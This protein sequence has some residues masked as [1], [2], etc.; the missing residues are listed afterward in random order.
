MYNSLSPY[1]HLKTES[2]LSGS[3]SSTCGVEQW[4][5]VQQ[6]IYKIHEQLNTNKKAGRR[7]GA[8]L[9]FW[10]DEG[11][12]SPNLE[13][14]AWGEFSIVGDIS[15][16]HTHSHSVTWEMNWQSSGGIRRTQVNVWWKK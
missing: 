15:S 13:Q 7:T 12:A 9:F 2:E 11:R 10:H 14:S 8:F 4:P 6:L 5:L 16:E 3:L 1:R